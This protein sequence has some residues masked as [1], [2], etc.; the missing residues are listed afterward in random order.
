MRQQPLLFEMF[1][2]YEI[3]SVQILC[4]K[5]S[6]LTIYKPQIMWQT[7]VTFE[8]NFWHSC[9]FVTWFV[10]K[11]WSQIVCGTNRNLKTKL[12]VQWNICG[13]K[14][15]INIP[16][17]K[18]SK[19]LNKKGHDEKGNILHFAAVS[20]TLSTTELSAFTF[21]FFIILL[22]VRC[23]MG[24]AHAAWIIESGTKDYGTGDSAAVGLFSGATSALVLVCVFLHLR[25]LQHPL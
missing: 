4:H 7:L 5:T 20:S 25:P 15:Q 12:Q 14:I 23:F 17:S 6:H 18:D 19:P 2:L 3:N 22:C 10:F 24:C 11:R 13:Y 9:L 1:L 21:S 8:E 16:G